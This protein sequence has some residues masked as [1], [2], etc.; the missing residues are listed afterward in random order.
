MRPSLSVVQTQVGD[1]TVLDLKGQLILDDGDTVFRQAVN[2][3]IDRDQLKI[4]VNLGDVSYID[5]AGIGVLIARYLGVKRRGGDMKLAN[6]TTRSHRVMTIT[7]L[8][9]VFDAFNSVEEAVRSFGQAQDASSL[10]DRR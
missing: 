10:Q 7:H 9:T 1:I 5:S 4:V 6:L 8:L 2:D 3:L